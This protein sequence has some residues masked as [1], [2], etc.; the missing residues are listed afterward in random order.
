[1]ATIIALFLFMKSVA[2]RPYIATA[3][4]SCM[5]KILAMDYIGFLF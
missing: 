3:E 4:P 1:M 2:V 5:K